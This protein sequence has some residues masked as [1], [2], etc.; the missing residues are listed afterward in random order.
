MDYNFFLSW[1][2]EC[3]VKRLET[4]QLTYEIW[5]IRSQLVMKL[6]CM[7]L[8][9]WLPKG[10]ALCHDWC[11][12]IR[13]CGSLSP[14]G[15]W[16]GAVGVRHT[17]T[18]QNPRSNTRIGGRKKQRDVNTFMAKKL[19]ESVPSGM[20]PQ[21]MFDFVF[22][23]FMQGSK[24]Q[25]HLENIQHK[26]IS[27]EYQ[28][29]EKSDKTLSGSLGAHRWRW[30]FSMLILALVRLCSPQLGYQFRYHFAFHCH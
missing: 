9:N 19:W 6:I 16:G 28:A 30:R 11:N 20:T 2:L 14:S 23:H 29:E 7:R 10:H 4:C 18:R 5:M 21:S 17:K 27:T 25:Y 1:R 15:T 24:G 3:K 8:V 22:E 26:C 13:I 12:I